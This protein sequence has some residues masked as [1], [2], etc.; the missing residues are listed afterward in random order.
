MLAQLEGRSPVIDCIAKNFETLEPGASFRVLRRWL[1]DRYGKQEA[2]RRILC[3]G[4]PAVRWRGWPR[5]RGIP[6]CLSRSRSGAGS[7]P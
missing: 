6:S 4:T 2:A 3:T 7:P 5:S 1:T